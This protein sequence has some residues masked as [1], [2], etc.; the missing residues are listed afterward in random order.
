MNLFE[1]HTRAITSLIRIYNI[2]ILKGLGRPV[3]K[4]KKN[5]YLRVL[6]LVNWSYSSS[7]PPLDSFQIY[8][9]P[10][11]AFANG[12]AFFLLQETSELISVLSSLV[13][14]RGSH[15]WGIQP[16][17]VEFIVFHFKDL[18]YY[19]PFYVLVACFFLLLN[20]IPL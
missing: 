16:I 17:S 18:A 8:P 12:L 10:T 5:N 6:W 2:L 1:K 20:S 4:I 11:S 14:P 9:T 3:F 13:Y 7:T 19:M 15:G